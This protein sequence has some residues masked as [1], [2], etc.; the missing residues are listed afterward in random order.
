MEHTKALADRVY[1]NEGLAAESLR[2]LTANVLLAL[3]AQIAIPVPWSPAPITGQTFGVLL[4][5]I[6]FGSRRGALALLLYLLEGISGLPVFQPFGM[7][8]PARFW[9]PTAGYLLAFPPAAFL[10]GWIFE[11]GKQSFRRLAGA[12]VSGEAVI[13]LSG[14]AWLAAES[15]AGFASAL[16]MGVLPF[17]PGELLKMALIVAVVRGFEFARRKA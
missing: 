10:T 9:G 8:G 17:I 2:I 11:R 14:C 12:L 3:C 13:L 1:T 6:L 15:G 5:A 4:V 7:P 16:R